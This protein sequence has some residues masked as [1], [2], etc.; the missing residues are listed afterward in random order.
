M[1]WLYIIVGII[2]VIIGTNTV[3]Y[4]KGK[5]IQRV[6]EN[7]RKIK[8]VEKLIADTRFNYVPEEISISYIVNSKKKLE[9]FSLQS[10][11]DS[12]ISTNE[13]S[14]IDF[15][16][17]AK[18]NA[19]NKKLFQEHFFT[20]DCEATDDEARNTKLSLKKF[21]EIE[22]NEI[23]KKYDESLK[24]AN[25]M[26]SVYI[27]ATYTTPAGKYTYHK[28]NRFHFSQIK[29]AV[30]DSSFRNSTVKSEKSSS[31]PDESIQRPHDINIK[32]RIYVNSFAKISFEFLYF[33]R[34]K[35]Y[36][37]REILKYLDYDTGQTLNFLAKELLS[38]TIIE[39]PQK[40]FSKIEAIKRYYESARLTIDAQ[41]VT[42]ELIKDISRYCY[43]TFKISNSGDVHIYQSLISA[44]PFEIFSF[45]N[46]NSAWCQFY[47]SVQ[48]ELNQINILDS[49]YERKRRLHFSFFKD[50][51]SYA[52]SPYVKFSLDEKILINTE[53]KHIFANCYLIQD[54]TICELNDEQVSEDQL[55][56]RSFSSK[57]RDIVAL[58]NRFISETNQKGYRSK[59]AF[60]KAILN[61]LLL[62]E[63][64]DNI[65]VTLSED[66][67]L[68]D[69][70]GI[71][72]NQKPKI[73][74]LVLNDLNEGKSNLPSHLTEIMRDYQKDC[75]KWCDKLISNDLNGIIADDMGLGKTLEIISVM[76]SNSSDL[77]NLIICPTSLTSNWKREFEKWSP[78]AKTFIIDSKTIL[79]FEK[80]N[81]AITYIINYEMLVR[82]PLLFEDMQ[83]N[84]I[85]LDEAQYIKNIRTQRA[86][87][88]N[89]L[90]GY[91][92]FALT[93]TPIENNVEE[94]WS[95]FSF[96]MPN[97][98]TEYKLARISDYYKKEYIKPFILRRKKRDVLKELPPKNEIFIPIDMT[99]RQKQFYDDMMKSALDYNDKPNE[100]L[101]LLIRLRQICISPKLLDQKYDVESSKIDAIMD[102]IDTTSGRGEK[103][104]IFSSFVT[105]FNIIGN[106]LTN[107]NIKFVKLIG[108]MNREDRDKAI[109]EFSYDDE[110]RIFLISLK[111]GGL[112]LNLVE[113][114]NVILVD[115][116]WNRAAEN[117]AIDRTHRIGQTKNVTIYKL[118]C[119]DTIEERVIE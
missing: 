97:L 41:E 107:K 37:E 90:K 57:G 43:I 49:I 23:A 83:F 108:E 101:G 38:L 56:L 13:R 80:H 45:Q 89:K 59:N 3:S 52:S 72:E 93:G 70:S 67:L 98:F 116:W 82:R 96:L 79:E 54:F 117:Q 115:P 7:S 44:V 76:I 92:R 51:F 50:N 34:E 28:E 27:K 75:F 14:V 64:N 21:R 8:H 110:I 87:R 55:K 77:S 12:I 16:D 73:E 40:F 71:L 81:D 15:Y 60:L 63:N 22:S 46:P 66:L 48:Q 102:I 91:H 88:I 94:L 6:T 36:D 5:R 32:A 2:A 35:Q 103:T 74:P 112:G 25:D 113:A 84:F 20:Q 47:N 17:K 114:N 42:E 24:K 61:F 109:N 100:I 69:D 119:T 30:D 111:A 53:L 10:A 26:F 1:E 99:D 11:F 68:L 106:L 65:L 62:T 33:A 105:T 104:L 118:V 29:K 18:E 95:I 19:I 9:K 39:D 78:G 85:V 86:R 4:V 58:L 31:N